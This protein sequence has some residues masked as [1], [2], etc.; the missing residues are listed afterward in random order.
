MG[1]PDERTEIVQKHST[2]FRSP[3]A[4]A[5][6]AA[7]FILAFLLLL[8]LLVLLLLLLLQFLLLSLFSFLHLFLQQILL[9]MLLF[10]LLFILMPC[11]LMFFRL[12]SFLGLLWDILLGRRACRLPSS[13]RHLLPNT[14]AVGGFRCCL[15]RL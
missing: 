5:V 6:V 4:S 8:L 1:N 15:A 13:P 3:V 10:F 12:W 9:L 14:K 7:F 11:L 2:T